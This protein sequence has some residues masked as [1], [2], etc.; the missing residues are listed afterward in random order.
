MCPD[1]KTALI[2]E[3]LYY[4][5]ARISEALG[6]LLREMKPINGKVEITIHGKG[7]KDRKGQVPAELI[8]RINAY[9]AGEI[10]LFEH[11]GKPYRR[12]YISMCIKRQARK[13]LDREISAHTLRHTRATLIYRETKNFKG[14]QQLLGHASN[15]T[16]MNLY[17]HDGFSA[18]DQEAIDRLDGLLN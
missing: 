2:F 4:S 10:F 5:A 17:V 3:F 18:E 6:L 9:F 15:A 8:E 13:I 7:S 11:N 1:K 16:T 12:E 14:I